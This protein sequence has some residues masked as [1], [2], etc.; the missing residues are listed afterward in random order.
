MNIDCEAMRNEWIL[1]CLNSSFTHGLAA[2]SAY[3]FSPIIGGWTSL[4]LAVS[5][6]VYAGWNRH[7]SLV[8]FLGGIT[9]SVVSWVS[10]GIYSSTE[11][12]IGALFLIPFSLAFVLPASLAAYATGKAMFMLTPQRGKVRGD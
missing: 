4:I 11:V 10:I 7:A 6:G 1:S 8:F 2:Y 5:V 9:F 12:G 3:A